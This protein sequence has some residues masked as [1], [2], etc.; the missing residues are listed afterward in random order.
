MSYVLS[1]RIVKDTEEEFDNYA[2]GFKYPTNGSTLFEP[3]YDSFEQAKTNLRNLLLTRKGERVMQPEFGTGLH[4]LLFEPM[5]D[6]Y[7]QKLQGAIL[8]SVGYWLPYITVEE[9][10]VEMTPEM[11]DRNTANLNIKFRVGETIDT[12]EITFTVQG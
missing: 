6:E 11:K 1:K 12:N 3:T 7:E 5:D 8:A 10:D 4:E 2:Y 9:I